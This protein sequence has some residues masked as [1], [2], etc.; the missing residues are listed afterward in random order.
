MDLNPSLVEAKYEEL[1][2]LNKINK[3]C[4]LIE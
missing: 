2:R 1:K 4:G 3:R